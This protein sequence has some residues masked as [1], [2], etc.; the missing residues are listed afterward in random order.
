MYGRAP[1]LWNSGALLYHSPPPD[2]ASLQVGNWDSLK[3]YRKG[4]REQLERCEI[5]GEF[6]VEDA[7]R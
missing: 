5:N 1:I 6:A 3:N 7:D 2:V 4:L